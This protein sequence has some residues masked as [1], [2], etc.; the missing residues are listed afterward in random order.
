MAQIEKRAY[1][2]MFGPTVGDRLRLADTDLFIEVEQDYTLSGGSSGEEV[3]FGGG[4][5]IRD[6]M[7]QSQ[8]TRNGPIGG[9]AQGGA[10]LSVGNNG[11]ANTGGGAGGAG[12]L[13][14]GSGGSGVVIVRYLKA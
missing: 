11:T 6:G 4:K 1:A 7:A 5:T 13:N 9:G 2:E 10:N 14:G 12:Y 3:M 8:G